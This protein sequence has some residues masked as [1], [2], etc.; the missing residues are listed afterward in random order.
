[1]YFIDRPLSA[2]TPTDDRPLSS[3]RDAIEKRYN[4]RY[5]IYISCADAR[6]DADTD[7]VTVAKRIREVLK[8]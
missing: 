4:E 7:A 8:K 6:I 3:D 5:P 1:M 2:L